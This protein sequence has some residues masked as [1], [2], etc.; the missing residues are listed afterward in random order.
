M[1]TCGREP[2]GFRV[3]NWRDFSVS[4]CTPF[5]KR[6]QQCARSGAWVDP[7]ELV[8]SI[9]YGPLPRRRPAPNL[10]SPGVSVVLDTFRPES[11]FCLAPAN[12]ERAGSWKFGLLKQ[13]GDEDLMP[14]M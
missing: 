5:S 9:S 7:E 4:A 1:H 2:Q 11:Y 6:T 12:P 10:S 3:L 8:L 13:P 14:G